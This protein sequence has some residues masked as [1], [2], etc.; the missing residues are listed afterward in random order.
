M[1]GRESLLRVTVSLVSLLVLSSFASAQ[2]APTGKIELRR[3]GHRQGAFYRGS[4]GRVSGH[5]DVSGLGDGRVVVQQRWGWGPSVF[6]IH[7]ERGMLEWLV[8]AGGDDHGNEDDGRGQIVATKTDIGGARHYAWQM[9]SWGVNDVN[10]VRADTSGEIKEAT[11][12]SYLPTAYW[13]MG[14]G[15][16]GIGMGIDYDNKNNI[17]FCGM[18]R[19][20][21]YNELM[22]AFRIEDDGEK[23]SYSGAT[24]ILDTVTS[25]GFWNVMPVKCDPAHSLVFAG[26]N[27]S[28]KAFLMKY[29]P[30]A[31]GPVVVVD[32]AKDIQRLF[33]PACAPEGCGSGDRL[34]SVSRCDFVVSG[35][36]LYVIAGATRPAGLFVFD[37]GPESGPYTLTNPVCRIP[38]DAGVEGVRVYKDKVIASSRGL[39]LLELGDVLA[40]SGRA[41]VPRS[42][43]PLP[44]RTRT[45]AIETV[46]GEDC[47]VLACGNDGLDVFALT[48]DDGPIKGNIVESDQK[49]TVEGGSAKIALRTEG[50]IRHL[51]GPVLNDRGDMAVWAVMDNEREAILIK[52]KGKDW[53]VGAI[54]GRNDYVSFSTP[55]INN[56]GAVVCYAGKSD[57]GAAILRIDDEGVNEIY[58]PKGAGYMMRPEVADDGAVVFLEKPIDGS[59]KILYRDPA[60]TLSD[61]CNPSGAP[62]RSEYY[63]IGPDGEVLFVDSN[64]AYRWEKGVGAN[65]ICPHKAGYSHVQVAKGGVATCRF[66]K[67]EREQVWVFKDI[68]AEDSGF[69]IASYRPPGPTYGFW[70]GWSTVKAGAAISSGKTIFLAR[71]WKVPFGTWLMKYK[72]KDDCDRLVKAGNATDGKTILD[73]SFAGGF[74][75]KEALNFIL[76]MK[77][78]SGKVSQALVTMGVE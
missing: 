48:G 49:I 77:D 67:W 64:A 36:H 59:G 74:N 24:K 71:T 65:K 68:S 78:A 43:Y 47:L 32:S 12:Y 2:T 40:A 35:G 15:H 11:Q 44:Y 75:E 3:I 8:S 58:T 13:D 61:V 29:A 73:V 6:K 17:L 50:G 23:A 54:A 10:L 25:T 22:T 62:G 45:F 42:S 55:S 76:D 30:Q 51:D 31:T 37:L 14:T 28:Y 34:Q 16:G 26:C 63:D 18:T 60:G 70:P 7:P 46:R 20:A 21:G 66:F 72:A 52:K 39:H 27:G 57:G 53:T 4:P 41:E 33:P 9:G 38:F 56:K 1:F 69:E 5:D 19:T